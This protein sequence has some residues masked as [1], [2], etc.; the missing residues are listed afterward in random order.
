M[1]KLGFCFALKFR[2]NALSQY[3]AQFDTPLVKRVNVPDDTL[4]KNTM[5]V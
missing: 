1:S 4:R 5:F 3:L 2:D